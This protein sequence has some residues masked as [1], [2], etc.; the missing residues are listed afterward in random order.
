V[1][2]PSAERERL[3]RV[4]Q[5]IVYATGSTQALCAASLRAGDVISASAVISYQI[6]LMDGSGNGCVREDGSSMGGEEVLERIIANIKSCPIHRWHGDG[7][8]D[9]IVTLSTI[10]ELAEYR[11]GSHY[12]AVYGGSGVADILSIPVGSGETIARV[13]VCR[14]GDGFSDEEIDAARILQPVVT[15][16]LRQTQVM[17]QL[18]SDPL[19]EEAMR[20]RGLTAREA[21]I[22]CRLASGATSQAAGQELGISVR[23]VEKHVQNIYARIGARNRS[24]AISILLG[25]SS[26]TASSFM[27]AVALAFATL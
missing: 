5:E 6:R 7:H 23:T 3:V 14:D 20:E 21:Q 8:D 15:G 9:E 19:S 10:T 25:N 16:C 24:E 1:D 17:E 26:A 4:I 2:K 22:F 13:L 18:R 11:D 27:A 12:K